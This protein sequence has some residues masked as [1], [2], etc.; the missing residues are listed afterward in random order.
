MAGGAAITGMYSSDLMLIAS[1]LA[2]S[3]PSRKETFSLGV[4]SPLSRLDTTSLK[5]ISLCA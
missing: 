4:M 1:L 3:K 2:P 5:P